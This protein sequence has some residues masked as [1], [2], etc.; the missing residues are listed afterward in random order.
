[1][2]FLTGEVANLLLSSVFGSVMQIM[3]A[4]SAA[5]ADMMKQLTANHKLE[6]ESRDKVRNNTNSFFQMTR[7]IV[8]LAAMFSIILV[9][10][11]APIIFDVPIYVQVE[12]QTGSDW[13]LFDTR[14]TTYVWQEVNGIPILEWHKHIMISIVSMY[15]GSSISKAR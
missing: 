6:E 9:P 14:N 13:L 1:M 7:R 5:Q 3:G 4:K 2:G 8:V 10:S 15:L 12:V 11:L